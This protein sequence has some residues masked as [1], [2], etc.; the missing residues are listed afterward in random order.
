M[1]SSKQTIKQTINCTDR[2]HQ[3]LVA[4]AKFQPFVCWAKI[5]S[6]EVHTLCQLRRAERNDRLE[7]VTEP[8]SNLK[9]L[10]SRFNHFE[11]GR[12]RVVP[13]VCIQNGGAV[14]TSSYGAQCQ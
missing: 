6:A 14:M 2:F 4:N 8:C 7:E 3:Y 13:F 11:R 12:E 1:Q 10:S 5:V 9:T